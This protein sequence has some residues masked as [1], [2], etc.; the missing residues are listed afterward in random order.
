MS[1]MDRYKHI[2][3]EVDEKKDSGSVFARKEIKKQA[4]Q[5]QRSQQTPPPQQQYTQQGTPPQPPINGNGGHYSNGGNGGNGPRPPQPPKM[6][7]PRQ[8]R[9]HPV[10]R[11]ILTILALLILYSGVAFALGRNAAKHDSSIPQ[12]E[13]QSFS[14]FKASNGAKNILLLGSDTREGETARADTVMVLQMKGFG[15]PK[16]ISFMRDTLVSIPGVGDTKLNAAYAYGGADLVRQTLSQN[17]GIECQYYAI[18]DFKSFEK[19]IDT[20]FSSGVK[21]DAEKDLDLDGVFIKK[22]PQKM[23]GHTLLQYARFRMDEEGDFGRVRRQ[24]Q[25]MNA[26]FSAMKNPITIAKLPYA[27]GKALGYA[28]TDVPMSFLLSRGI[29]ILRGAGGID[30]LSVPVDDSWEYGTTYDGASV[31]VIDKDK[32]KTAVQSFLDK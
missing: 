15:K 14:G 25:T 2:H 1:R 16:L 10:M 24:Q 9:K 5:P 7:Q 31:L 32:N 8:R 17:F 26:I 29:N 18:V 6:K 23:D 13:T 30:R 27:A 19:V 11:V 20:L 12:Q 3:E 28:S 4:P 22:G 21:I